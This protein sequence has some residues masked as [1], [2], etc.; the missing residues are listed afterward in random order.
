MLRTTAILLAL[1][2]LLCSC[3]PEGSQFIGFN[4]CSPGGATVWYVKPNAQGKVDTSA[5]SPAN[6]KH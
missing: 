4:S 3:A 2:Y 6:C 5:F 1:G